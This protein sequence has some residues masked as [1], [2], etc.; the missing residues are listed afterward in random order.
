[1]RQ[2]VLKKKANPYNILPSTISRTRAETI[3]KNRKAV[4]TTIKPT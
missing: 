3:R 4:N 2:K 1:M